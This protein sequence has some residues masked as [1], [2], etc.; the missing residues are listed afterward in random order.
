MPNI[1]YQAYKF[2]GGN[3]SCKK[4]KAMANNATMDDNGNL[5]LSSF[6]EENEDFE[7]ANLC[8]KFSKLSTNGHCHIQKEF[9]TNNVHIGELPCEVINYIIKWIVSS[10]LALF[11][12]I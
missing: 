10:F 7:L 4:K 3:T 6:D 12:L 9:E 2:N 5:E 1:E 11:T 8:S